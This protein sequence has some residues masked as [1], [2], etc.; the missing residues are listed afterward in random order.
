MAMMTRLNPDFTAFSGTDGNWLTED[1]TTI[2]TSAVGNPYL[3]T[4]RRGGIF[5]TQLYYYRFRD[6]SP[7][8]GR[9]L[10]PDP[11]GYIDGLNLYAYC[12]NNPV[13]RVDPM[14]LWWGSKAIFGSV[15]A[16]IGT[17]LTLTGHGVI[18]VP[19]IAVGAGLVL[20]DA[21]DTVKDDGTAEKILEKQVGEKVDGLNEKNKELQQD[22][23]FDLYPNR[24]KNGKCE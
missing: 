23:D 24:K 3:F 16:I 2:N 14:G 6:Y 10:Q 8:I 19:L 15:L 22:K 20:W 13:N 17:G 1:G 7:L 9:F 21:Y 12:A 5:Y 11:L 18:G 4:A